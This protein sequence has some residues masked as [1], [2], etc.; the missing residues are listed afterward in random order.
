MFTLK[1]VLQ[2][3]V[4][5]TTGKAA[6]VV[7]AGKQH[8]QSRSICRKTNLPPKK[9]YRWPYE[10]YGLNSFTLLF[11]PFTKRKFDE[12]SK[13]IVIE[14]N[15]ASGKQELAKKLAD[16]FGM[17]YMPPNLDLEKIYINEHGYDYR[18]L[19]PLLPE[20]MRI[21]DFKMFH[22]NPTRLSVIHL[23]HHCF[24]LRLHQYLLALRHLFNTGQG[25]VLTRCVFNDAVFV[26][27]M[28]NLGWLPT[29]YLRGDGVRFYDWK[30]R[31]DYIRQF[32]LND[33]L[34]PEL[35]IYLDT[36][37]DKCLE[38][39]RNDP[40]P[41]IRNSKAVTREFLEEMDHAYKDVVL[42][43]CD[44]N[45][46]VHMVPNDK[47]LDEHEYTQLIDDIES[48]GFEYDPHDTRFEEWQP[49]MM[50]HHG[51]RL[52]YSS[53]RYYR[54]LFGYVG[55]MKFYD[56]A[57]LGD[58]IS[59]GDLQLRDALYETHVNDLGFLQNF[60]QDV[61]VHGFLK[62]VFNFTPSEKKFEQELRGDFL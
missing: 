49:T 39:I 5:S 55:G 14:G 31:Y 48:I 44:L 1:S 2:S 52:K 34:K 37:V 60:N 3:P 30:V 58:M 20:R 45:G 6:S 38:N 36:P 10:K 33:V 53:L 8:H 13:I 61:R 11:D 54:H 21:C 4:A 16:E 12:N 51:M 57:G 32:V 9:A 62:T 46:I 47:P 18:A 27:T 35:T 42:P 25:V 41:M 28:Q 43:R 22:E 50:W 17:L 29:G 24:R 15:V 26:E 7:L 19:N 23:Q 56:I 59:H 40:D